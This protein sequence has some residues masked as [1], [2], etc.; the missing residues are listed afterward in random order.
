MLALMAN[1]EGKQQNCPYGV[2]AKRVRDGLLL[3][4]LSTDVTFSDKN[5][6]KDGQQKSDEQNLE[7]LNKK[8]KKCGTLLQK[9]TIHFSILPWNGG[10]VA[11]R[12]CV[13]YFDYDKMKCKPCLRTRD[14]GDY[15]IMDKEGRRK[16]LGRYFIDTKIPASDRD[17]QL[18][19]ADGSHIMWII[20]GRISEFYKVSSET[21]RVLRV[22]VQEKEEN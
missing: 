22:S 10:K 3:M 4:K 1:K 7:N 11:K 12:D 5:K 14:T 13:K 21:K 18:L 15:F 19:L 6:Q 8:N 20:G 17:G 2:L 9:F 16:S